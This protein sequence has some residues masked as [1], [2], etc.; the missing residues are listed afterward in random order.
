LGNVS[1]QIKEGD[2]N[3]GTRQNLARDVRRTLGADSRILA[4]CKS[5]ISGEEVIRESKILTD[6]IHNGHFYRKAKELSYLWD[7]SAGLTTIGELDWEVG[8]EG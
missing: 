7:G 6:L 3:E 2:L 4:H 5:A 1:H 8:G